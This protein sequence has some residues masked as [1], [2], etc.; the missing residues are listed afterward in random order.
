[1]WMQGQPSDSGCSSNLSREVSDLIEQMKKAIRE[2]EDYFGSIQ[3]VLQNQIEFED[4][5]LH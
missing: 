1:M 2:L 4:H 5:N 3:Q